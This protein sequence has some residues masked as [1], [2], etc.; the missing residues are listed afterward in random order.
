MMERPWFLKTWVEPAARPSGGRGRAIV[1]GLTG[2]MGVFLALQSF[3]IF[4][5]APA[6]QA[7][8]SIE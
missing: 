2:V 5:A 6:L 1:W 7:G 3:W 8:P 4:T